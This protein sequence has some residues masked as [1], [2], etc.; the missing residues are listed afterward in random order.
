MDKVKEFNILITFKRD[1]IASISV[2]IL[3]NMRTRTSPNKKLENTK[4]Q[5]EHLE[6][7]YC[8]NELCV[9][10]PCQSFFVIIST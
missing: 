4:P 8:L 9:C 7:V 10:N 3:Q 5:F 6:K 1:M 2:A